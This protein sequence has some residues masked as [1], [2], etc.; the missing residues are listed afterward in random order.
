MRVIIPV[1]SIVKL[2][3]P[4][5]DSS[6]VP[7]EWIAAP[8]HLSRQ[9]QVM[10]GNGINYWQLFFLRM[11][12]KTKMLQGCFHEW[13]KSCFQEYEW[14]V[15]CYLKRERKDSSEKTML[16]FHQKIVQRY[17]GA[18]RRHLATILNC[19]PL[20]FITLYEYHTSCVTDA[21]CSG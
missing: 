11:S 10:H 4:V 3:L 12:H 14:R 13:V 7:F 2:H 15:W 19:T 17:E 5:P 20:L 16:N 9:W 6:S 1:H 18:L 8:V 21:E